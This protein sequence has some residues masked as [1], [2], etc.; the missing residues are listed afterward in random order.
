MKLQA[1]TVS[2]NYSDF[3]VHSL[4]ANKKLFDKWVIV[5]DT[6]DNKTK[7][8]CDSHGV[9]CIQTDVFYKNARFNKYAGINEGLKHIDKDAWV[10]FLDSDIILQSDTP[11]VLRELHLDITRLYGIDRLNITGYERWEEFKK[12]RGLLIE[13]WLLTSQKLELGSRLVHYYGHEGENGRFEGWRPLGFFQLCHRTSFDT[14]PQQ[15][16]GA[17]HCD[18]LFARLWPRRK[19]EFI[20]ELMAIHLESHGTGKAMNWWGRRSRPFLPI[21]EKE[22]KNV[23]LFK[24]FKKLLKRL[25]RWISWTLFF[26]LKFLINLFKCQPKPYR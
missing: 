11:R 9:V 8:L 13:N 24:I 22:K 19:R 6:K 17:D 12:S 26:I 20:P 16:D 14:Y 23:S 7:E 25:Y 21:E 2:V 10:V 1:V 18:L 3:L 5:T 4:K 15:T